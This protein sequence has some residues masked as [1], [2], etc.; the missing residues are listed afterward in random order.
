[1]SERPMPA[2]ACCAQRDDAT[3]SN[4]FSIKRARLSLIRKLC[5]LMQRAKDTAPTAEAHRRWEVALGAVVL[6][7]DAEDR[8]AKC[9]RASPDLPIW[10]ELD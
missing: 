2:W 5:G 4:V 9:G 10:S 1:M 8:A 6:A 7:L 3:D